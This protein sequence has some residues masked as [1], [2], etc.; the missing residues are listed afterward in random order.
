MVGIAAASMATRLIQS[1]L[2][3]IDRGDLMTF[4][5]TSVGLIV[6][7]LAAS[8]VPA[9]RAASVDPLLAMRGE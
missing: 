9:R 8:Y 1:W 7:S 6:V 5:L 2:F 3:G 4:V